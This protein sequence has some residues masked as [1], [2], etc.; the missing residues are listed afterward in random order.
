MKTRLL[1]S[2][3]VVWGTLNRMSSLL[4]ERPVVIFLHIPKAAGLTLYKILNREY[5][6]RYIYTFPGGRQRLQAAIDRFR[7]LPD[8]QR[9]RYDLLRGHFPF[10]AHEWINRPATYITLLREPVARVVSH[11]HYVKRTPQHALY[12]LVTEEKM[13][14]TDYVSSGINYEMDNGQTRQI[15][16][17]NDR[18]PFGCCSPELLSVARQLLDDHF[19]IVGLVEH[20]DETLLLLRQRL[21]WRRYPVYVRQNV[22]RKRPFTQELS[23]ATRAIIEKHNRLDCELYEYA[24]RRFTA[25]L[26]TLPEAELTRFQR[27]N[28]W[29]YPWG[30]I[31]DYF[32]TAARQILQRPNC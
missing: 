26:A 29:Y 1:W 20:F 18:V 31:Q 23:P 27:R 2:S 19:S 9:D 11:Y 14:L 10:G 8:S 7:T 32:M 17:I 22:T 16:G 15:T 3:Y 12:P 13:T 28:R 5:G 6:R 30:R 25:Q 24:A 4:S 21:G